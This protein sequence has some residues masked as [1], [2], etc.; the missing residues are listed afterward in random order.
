MYRIT[1][2]SGRASF[3]SRAR[4]KLRSS[5][6]SW[7]NDTISWTVLGVSGGFILPLRSRHQ[8]L[9]KFLGPGNPLRQPLAQLDEV[10]LAPRFLRPLV[11]GANTR[12]GLVH[13]V[14]RQ[15]GAGVLLVGV[16]VVKLR[17][18]QLLQALGQALGEGLDQLRAQLLDLL[19]EQREVDLSPLDQ[20]LSLPVGLAGL[21]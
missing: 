8:A 14:Q 5:K 6:S 11:E 13:H 4:A 12:A 20:R 19:V 1:L 2:R 3:H 18:A 7:Q 16:P 9:H 17:F 15:P 10:D 21:E